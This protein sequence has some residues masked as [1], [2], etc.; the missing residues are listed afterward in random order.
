M[1]IGLIRGK[2]IITHETR[3]Q[4]LDNYVGVWL[5]GVFQNKSPA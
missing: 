5:E 3:S 4:L 1:A 2:I